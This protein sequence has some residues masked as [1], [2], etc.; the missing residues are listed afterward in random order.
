MREIASF[1]D[2]KAAKLFAD[3]LCARSID[4]EISRAR[5]GGVVV[6]AVPAVHSGYRPP[7]GV[8]GHDRPAGEQPLELARLVR[9]SRREDRSQSSHLTSS[10]PSMSATPA[11]TNGAA[12]SLS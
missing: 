8:E 3:V 6:R 4:T 5:D 10:T 2:E 1:P 12:V 11:T 7:L 9:V